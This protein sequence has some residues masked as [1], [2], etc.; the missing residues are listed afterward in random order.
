[1]SLQQGNPVFFASLGQPP[2]L[3]AVQ[4]APL[5]KFPHQDSSRL[6]SDPEEKKNRDL[7]FA[8]TDYLV[9]TIREENAGKRVIFVF[10]APKW[11]IYSGELAGSGVLWMHEMM[12]EICASNNVEYIDLVPLMEAD[13]AANGRKFNSEVDGHWDE[14]GHEFVAKVLYDYLNGTE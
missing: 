1:M 13:Y 11:A 9:R 3:S 14:Y 4:Q 7:V 5:V 12:N 6:L 2:T 8:A 10:D